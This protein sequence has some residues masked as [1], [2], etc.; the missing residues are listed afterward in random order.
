MKILGIDPGA[1]QSA[2]VVWDGDLIISKGIEKNEVLNSKLRDWGGLMFPMV[3]EQIRCYGMPIGQTTL[4]TVFW[5]GR[6]WESWKGERHL[7]PRL[8]VKKHL[9]HNGSAKDTNIITALADRF[10][11]GETNRGKGTKKEPGFFY[12]FKKDIWQAFALAV[13]WLDQAEE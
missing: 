8:E 13:A 7:M 10:A 1:T 12:G 5:S 3:I 4:D 2:F 6:F 11:Y 9:C